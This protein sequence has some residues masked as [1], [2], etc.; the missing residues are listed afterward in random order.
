MLN[1]ISE[2]DETQD[3]RNRIHVAEPKI[4]GDMAFI[5][6]MVVMIQMKKLHIQNSRNFVKT[7][8]DS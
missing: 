5:M 8:L 1:L 6:I 7:S 4:A 3:G 2:C